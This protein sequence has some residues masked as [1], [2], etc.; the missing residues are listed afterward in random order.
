MPKRVRRGGLF[1]QIVDAVPNAMVMVNTAGRVEM[2]NAQAERLFGYARN[3]IRGQSIE[4]LVP[5]RFRGG[6]PGQRGA[7]FATA[8]TGPMAPGR[9]VYALRKD[10]HEFP[11]EIGLNPIATD[12][13]PMVLV[14][15]MDISDRKREDERLRAALREKDVLLGEIHHRFKS[16]LQIVYSLLHL[17]SARTTDPAAR[18]LLSDSQ[19]R[20]HSMALI[21]KTLN[22]SSDFTA[23]DFARFIGTLLPYLID[24]HGI[25]TDRIAIRLDV[26]PIHLPVDIAIPCG[27]VL[28]ELISNAFR[29]AF[30]DRDHG[31]VHVALTRQPGNEILLMVS[32]DGGG[33]P[34][35]L[36][37][38]TTGTLGLHLVGILGMQIDGTLSIERSG[39]TRLSVRFP[40]K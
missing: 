27:L 19:S 17:Q 31:E 2:V 35:D 13:G 32:D 22:G 36:D 9:D 38:T 23:V 10:G 28:N 7:W 26:E 39:P 33:L 11:V 20:V 12:D 25:D 29:H 4:I 1:R 3:E 21:H 30:R 40:I 5:E 18:K 37:V 16:N 24:T 8:R 15:I 6:H 14:A 34:D